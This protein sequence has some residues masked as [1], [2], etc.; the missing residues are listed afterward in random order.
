MNDVCCRLVDE[1]YCLQQLH[2]LMAFYLGGASP[3]DCSDIGTQLKFCLLYM[4]TIKHHP[5][6][7]S[8]YMYMY[9]CW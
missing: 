7:W 3:C 6:I 2:A 9:C 8:A 1:V 4:S 5:L